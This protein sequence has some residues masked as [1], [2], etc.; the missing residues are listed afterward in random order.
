M[1]GQNEV[2]PVLG[3]VLLMVAIGVEVCATALL[4]RAQGFTDPAWS[5]LVVVGYGLSIWLL[6]V[7]VRHM[8]VSIAYAI[9]AGVGTAAVAVI[10]FVFLG[11]SMN[12]MKAFS[13]ALIVGGVIGLNAA[14]T[15]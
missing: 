10:G 3:A 12:W 15:H 6:T 7:V 4:P 2:D 8:P 5:V 11:E 14:G 1:N 13:I 9:W